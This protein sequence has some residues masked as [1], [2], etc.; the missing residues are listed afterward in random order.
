MPKLWTDSI[1][2]HHEAV[3]DAIFA[4]TA[5]IVT[6]GGFSALSMARIAQEAGI[7]RATLYK[8]FGDLDQLLLAWHQRVIGEHLQM[9][10]RV[11]ASKDDPRAALE[12]VL[13][14]FA[15]IR[16]TDHGQLPTGMLHSLPHVH[17]AQDH[18]RALLR[19]LITAAARQGSVRTDISAD[20]LA[21]F[22]LAALDQPRG[23]AS[24]STVRLILKAMDA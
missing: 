21:G 7:G 9:V 13:G 18:L 20:E 12:A 17:R 1:E 15:D 19:K 8:Y 23:V 10:E 6:E 3:A 24:K 22:A 2:A 16:R 14:A 5:R 4:A 11:A